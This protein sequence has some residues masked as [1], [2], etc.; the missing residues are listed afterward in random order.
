MRIA[1]YQ[2]DIAGNVGAI[3]RTAACLGLAVD[4]IEPMGFTWNEKAVA[5]SGMDYVG[6]VEI[7]RHVDWAAFRDQVRG[8]IV[9][10][11]TKGAVRLDAATF[12]TDD[13]LLMGSE[14]AGVPDDVHARA[15]LRV[16]IPMRPGLRSMNISVATAIVAAEALRQTDGWPA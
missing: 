8:R 10:L 6:A 7:V 16:L 1:L 9:L 11:T 12:Q 14:G 13:V 2:P 3:L 15:D 4:L 5:R